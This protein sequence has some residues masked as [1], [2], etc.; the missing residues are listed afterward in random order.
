MEGE[1]ILK[2]F[3]RLVIMKNPRKIEHVIRLHC[4][5]SHFLPASLLSLFIRS[6]YARSLFLSRP[7]PLYFLIPC[8]HWIELDFLS[9]LILEV[10]FFLLRGHS[11]MRHN[12][13]GG[14]GK[15]ILTGC[16]C[17]SGEGLLENRD[18]T[19]QVL[20]TFFL[21]ASP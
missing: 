9:T 3:I 6:C 12:F 2:S 1:R 15:H 20:I 11:E 18:I 14:R 7:L 21:L 16:N 4:Y 8:L 10:C 19:T 5:K 13:R 17:S